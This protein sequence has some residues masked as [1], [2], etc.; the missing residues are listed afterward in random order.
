[1]HGDNVK[2]PLLFLEDVRCV[3]VR[4]NNVNFLF[5]RGYWNNF[6][7]VETAGAVGC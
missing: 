7:F 6:L 4:K 1:M 3:I 2:G 5:L